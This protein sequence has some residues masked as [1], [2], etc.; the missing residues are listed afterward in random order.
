MTSCPAPSATPLRLLPQGVSTTSH[1]NDVEE[2]T[3]SPL[4][5]HD[6]ND[7]SSEEE[8][9]VVLG[10]ELHQ[11]EQEAQSIRRARHTRCCLGVLIFLSFLPALLMIATMSPLLLVL[12]IA[13]FVRASSR[14]SRIPFFAFVPLM[15]VNLV[16]MYLY[17]AMFGSDGFLV[18]SLILAILASAGFYYWQK[19]QRIDAEG[20]QET[21]MRKQQLFFA[22]L[23][24]V[25]SV[26]QQVR[27][28][29]PN[30]NSLEL[31][32]F[33]ATAPSEGFYQGITA[34]PVKTTKRQAGGSTP[35]PSTAEGT[36]QE[37]N[38]DIEDESQL[39]LLFPP[40]DSG[41]G[42]RG[43]RL[44]N[45]SSTTV[46]SIILEGY[47][48]PTHEVYW[49]EG[50][51]DGTENTLY[52]GKFDNKGTFQGE[53]LSFTG[54]QSHQYSMTLQCLADPE[55]HLGLACFHCRRNP[56]PGK[57][58]ISKSLPQR[59]FCEACVEDDPEL[60]QEGDFIELTFSDVS[61]GGASYIPPNSE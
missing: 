11:L 43:A 35:Q 61:R 18:F 37:T 1:Q 44:S 3:T 40:K 13:C 36:S 46:Q 16:A 42:V 34:L 4:L 23:E 27:N 57:C 55:H 12:G 25:K 22:Y 21:S 20:G 53:W 7:R 56:H 19:Q 2:G 10:E 30:N 9:T 26:A 6:G 52:Y 33:H 39:F 38:N 24:T 17:D 58:F 60:V 54:N 29:T 59:H 49:T 28:E 15:L 14:I 48:S 8:H 47:L 45:D 51:L 31:R 50:T 5:L 32:V 41:W